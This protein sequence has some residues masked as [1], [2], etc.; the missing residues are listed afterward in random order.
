VVS[1]DGECAAALDG[2]I[3]KGLLEERGGEL[4]RLE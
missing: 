4:H 1:T 2:A 3:E